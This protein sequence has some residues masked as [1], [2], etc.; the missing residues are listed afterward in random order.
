MEILYEIYNQPLNFYFTKTALILMGIAL[1]PYNNLGNF[2][3]LN[4]S[5][6]IHE[7]GMYFQL[8]RVSLISCNSALKLISHCGPLFPD[9]A[10]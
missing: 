2:W 9:C 6:P 8:F 1:N 3:H 5:F 10:A 7:Y 4:A